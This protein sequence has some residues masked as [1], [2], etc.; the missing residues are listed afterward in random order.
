[1][2]KLLIVSNRLPVT[3]AA[4]DLEPRLVP[5]TGGLATGL[6]EP[7]RRSGGVWIGWPGRVAPEDAPERASVLHAL[8]AGGMA[9]VW[10]TA[11]EV[12]IDACRIASQRRR[13]RSSDES[14]NWSVGRTSRS[15]MSMSG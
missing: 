8:R 2:G 13:K 15:S 4:D 11:N 9:P 6:R 7:H 14:E 5:S 1:M 12:S 3:L 10:L